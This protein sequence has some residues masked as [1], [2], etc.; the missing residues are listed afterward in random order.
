MTYDCSE[1]LSQRLAAMKPLGLGEFFNV[2]PDVLSLGLG[3]PDFATPAPACEGA[4]TS[5]RLGRTGYPTAQ[6]LPELRQE[7]SAYLERRFGYRY[8]PEQIL[9]TVGGSGAF[10]CAMRALLDEGDQVLAPQPAFAFYETA[11]ELSGGGIVPLPTRAEQNFRLT[12]GA[13]RA[14]LTPRA[15]L[16]LL[17]YPN[18]PTGAALESRDYAELA[19]A[20]RETKLLAVSDEIY[21]EFSYERPHASIL[22]QPGM[23]ERTLL[24]SGFSKIFA[25][26]GWRLGYAAGPAPLISGMM[27]IQQAALLTA[28]AVAQYAALAGLRC[29]EGEV[30]AMAA[31]YCRRRD[32]AFTRLQSMGLPCVKP[33]GAFYLFPSIKHTGLTSKQFAR[34]LRDRAKVAVVPGDAFGPAGEGFIR[35]S[36]ATG[37][38]TLRDSLDRLENFLRAREW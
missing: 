16:L 31:E 32:Y 18:N 11:V 22:H 28:P 17:T 19:A 33:A 37:M 12:A 3:E 8:A 26:A 1:L 34:E 30:A 5:L 13:L 36:Y 20:L 15:K 35:I 10:D 21:A 9:I 29:C 6:G 24:L 4:V 27:R 38:E 7:I 23:A 2:P 14:A 25:M